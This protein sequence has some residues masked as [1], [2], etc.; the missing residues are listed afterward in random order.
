MGWV[1]FVEDLGKQ[2]DDAMH[3]LTMMKAD[4]ESLPP[5]PETRRK[6]LR[7]WSDNLHAAWEVLGSYLDEMTSGAP[8]VDQKDALERRVCE[9]LQENAALTVKCKDLVDRQ[10]EANRRGYERGFQEGVLAGRAEANRNLREENNL[11][12]HMK[13]RA[14]PA[15]TKP[16][17]PAA[18]LDKAIER[19]M[20]DEEILREAED[21]RSATLEVQMPKRGT[22][23]RV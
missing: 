21:A 17:G 15:P 8:L 1:S 22:K 19:A 11:L 16:S 5:E 7:V 3:V 10:P 20:T 13:Q 2:R 14:A 4:L 6:L 18:P 9:L 23:N 12:K